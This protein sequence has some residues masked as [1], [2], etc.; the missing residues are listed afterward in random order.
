MLLLLTCMG[1]FSMFRSV[2]TPHRM[3]EVWLHGWFSIVASHYCG[4]A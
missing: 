1:Y 2:S 3:L 4:L